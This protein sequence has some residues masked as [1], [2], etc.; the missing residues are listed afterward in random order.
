MEAKKMS[1]KIK[2]NIPGKP[3]Y[4]Q[5]I[6]MALGTLASNA[7][8]DM[9]KVDD[10][11]VAV[12]EACKLIACHGHEGGFSESYEIEVEKEENRLVIVVSDFCSCGTIDRDNFKYCMKCPEEGDMS[13]EVIATLM[14]SFD[15]EVRED[16]NKKLTMV[17]NK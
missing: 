13:K 8:Y 17:K 9:E 6:R 11:K 10:I 3:E 2:F 15:I 5:M 14:D 1:D 4:L 16:G 7:G 12:E